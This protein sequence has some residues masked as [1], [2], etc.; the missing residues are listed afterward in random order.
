M[1]T[2]EQPTPKI[3]WGPLL[4]SIGITLAIGISASFFTYPEIESWYNLLKKPSFTPPRWLF[5]PVWTLLYIMI[6]YS[7]YLMWLKRDDSV[8]FNKAR[9][10]YVMQLLCNF[11]WSYI[12]FKM[13]NPLG[14][15][16]IIFFLWVLIITCIAYFR[17]IDKKAAWLLVP[18]LVWVTFAGILNLSILLLNSR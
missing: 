18:Y 15:M 3:Q 8:I 14:G 6:G 11:M 12:F 16:L 4:I 10:V 17:H 9:T 1:S 2:L 13:H 5:A 7:A